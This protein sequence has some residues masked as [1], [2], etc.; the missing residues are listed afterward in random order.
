MLP[1]RPNEF[2]YKGITQLRY[3]SFLRIYEKTGRKGVETGG[4]G[5]K[6]SGD[7]DPRPLSGL[8]LLISTGQDG[9]SDAGAIGIEQRFGLR[10]IHLQLI[11]NHADRPVHEFM[12]G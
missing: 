2:G 3:I 9:V 10:L 12:I 8:I 5:E 7:A 1:S 4:T 11:H 6:K